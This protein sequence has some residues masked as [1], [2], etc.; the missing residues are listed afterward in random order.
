[1]KSPGMERTE[2]LT[3]T[4]TKESPELWIDRAGAGLAGEIESRLNE[5]RRLRSRVRLRLYLAG[6][7]ARIAFQDLDPRINRIPEEIDHLSSIE[8]I[9]L[10]STLASAVRALEA[11]V[12]RRRGET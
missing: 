10:I 7:D 3:T 1:M 6:I 11:L 2:A 4:P 8:A 9:D 12:P 5:L